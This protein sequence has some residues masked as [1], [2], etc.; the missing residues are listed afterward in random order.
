[1]STQEITPNN[2]PVFERV[3]LIGAGLI[4]SSLAWASRKKG[5][6]RHVAVTSRSAARGCSVPKVMICAT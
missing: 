5:L 2:D 3:A 6:A 1:M 4:G